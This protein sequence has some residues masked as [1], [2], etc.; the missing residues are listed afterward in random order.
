MKRSKRGQSLVEYAFGVGCV[1][2]VAMVALSAVGHLGG[3][4]FWNVGNSIN[5]NGGPG[6]KTAHPE[7]MI[8][9]SQTPWNLQ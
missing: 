5:Y 1:S 3:H 2:A 4:V 7:E 6:T 9:F 8:G